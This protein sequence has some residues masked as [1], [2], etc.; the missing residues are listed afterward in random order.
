M[1]YIAPE[2]SSVQHYARRPRRQ[3]PSTS[4]KQPP[5][6]RVES[7]KGPVIA[8]SSD[9]KMTK[10]VV[11]AI[12]AAGMAAASPYCGHLSA[13]CGSDESCCGGLK[14]QN[15]FCEHDTP[16]GYT[17]F[18]GVDS[19]GGYIIPVRGMEGKTT[20]DLASMCDALRFCMGFNSDG[21]LKYDILDSSQRPKL[22]ERT[23]D[24][25]QAGLYTKNRSVADRYDF[26]PGVDS[27]VRDI[28]QIPGS[29]IESIASA[30]D[31]DDECFGFN[32]NGWLKKEVLE[33]LRRPRVPAGRWLDGRGG[34][35]TKKENL[36]TGWCDAEKCV[37][38]GARTCDEDGYC[39]WST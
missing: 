36:H 29:N 18:P 13:R 38:G 19:P 22:S 15:D 1:L 31:A 5:S 11:L 34:L 23:R 20:H 27:P 39:R 9:H 33:S 4:H 17:F 26:F 28:R 7:V 16:D 35:Y 8:I 3:S 12:L 24:D 6:L 14:C 37:A 32:S 10:T 2:G 21:V 30:C 25:G